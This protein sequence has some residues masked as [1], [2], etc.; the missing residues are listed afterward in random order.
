M[1]DELVRRLKDLPGVCG[2]AL[3]T[4]ASLQKLD[5]SADSLLSS[6]LK[7]LS[8]SGPIEMAV[9]LRQLPFATVASKILEQC[10]EHSV[11]LAPAL[12]LKLAACAL[13]TSCVDAPTAAAAGGDESLVQ[14]LSSPSVRSSVAKPTL[15]KSLAHAWRG[16]LAAAHH[17]FVMSG[18][19]PSPAMHRI[20][21]LAVKLLAAC[22]TDASVNAQASPLLLSALIHNAEL[23]SFAVEELALV[24]Q[25]SI[26]QL[27]NCG[28]EASKPRGSE[29]SVGSLTSLTSLTST[30]IAAVQAPCC[31][32]VEA[33]GNATSFASAAAERLAASDAL[34]TSLADGMLRQSL[35]RVKERETEPEAWTWL[36][37]TLVELL[38]AS[39]SP[40][41][42]GAQCLLLYL[43]KGLSKVAGASQHAE[44]TCGQREFAVR[45]LGQIAGH[46]FPK[47]PEGHPE[48]SLQ[49]LQQVCADS[50]KDASLDHEQLLYKFLLRESTSDKS[51]A[52][53]AAFLLCSTGCPPPSPKRRKASKASKASKEEGWK[54]EALGKLQRSL[55]FRPAKGMEDQGSLAAAEE[56]YRSLLESDID[57]CEVPK[58]VKAQFPYWKARSVALWALLA[59][60]KSSPLAHVRRQALC[61]LVGAC[62]ST[63]PA[64]RSARDAA[65]ALAFNDESA[66]IRAAAVDFAEKLFLGDELGSKAIKEAISSKLSDPA[67]AVRRSAFRVSCSMLK[68][69]KP[70]MD[71]GALL[72]QSSE[73]IRLCWDEVPQTQE[74]V[75]QAVQQALLPRS[76]PNSAIGLAAELTK[77][78]GVG[79]KGLQRLLSAHHADLATKA[80]AAKAKEGKGPEPGFA[81]IAR[82]SL[83]GLQRA[84][85]GKHDADANP[86]LFLEDLAP[87]T[88]ILE[89][90][91]YLEPVAVHSCV[92][93][94]IGWLRDA[95]SSTAPLQLFLARSACRV[96]CFG[97]IFS[98]CDSLGTWVADEGPSKKDKEQA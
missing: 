53:S 73:L 77:Q 31:R 58:T 65:A 52:C 95:S 63:P 91:A 50:P 5:A 16:L 38:M 9:E 69:L 59:Q 22:K 4:E 48:K 83:G 39:L 61:G 17:Q 46:G 30:L 32:A 87:W 11:H 47:T 45:L 23:A 78:Q 15:D 12:S 20:L 88:L 42:A 44:L 64:P 40:C 1:E 96:L 10:D 54:I 35:L 90:A 7:T 25:W 27:A 8:T 74:M 43:A 18:F 6:S 37:Q 13:A 3:D 82:E 14:V 21:P 33:E 2:S 68:L 97:Y 36:E 29:L 75:F 67:P 70:G 86:L 80:K 92:P 19:L 81:K 62:A 94:M 71:S 98:R 89:Q 24:P 34:A 55:T 26:T 41:Y 72:S 56:L 49:M 76:W 57:A 60:L 84:L 28:S 51:K 85:K 79:S 93:V 66:W